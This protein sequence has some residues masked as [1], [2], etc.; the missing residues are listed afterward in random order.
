VIDSQRLHLAAPRILLFAIFAIRVT[1]IDRFAPLFD[2]DMTRAVVN[3]VLAGDFRNNWKFADVPKDFHIDFYNFSS[4][5]YVDAAFVKLALLLTDGPPAHPVHWHRMCS[6]VAGTF[7]VFLFYLLAR[8]WFDEI[9]ALVFLALAAVAPI[10]VQDAHYA[11]PEAVEILLVGAVYLL[12]NQLRGPT[13][14]YSILAVSCACVGFLGAMKFS[15]LPMLAV[16]LF[17]VPED[18][19]KARGNVVRVGATAI[20]STIAGMFAGV[21]H[22]FFHPAGY[23]HGVRVLQAQYAGDPRDPAYEYAFGVEL[24]YFWWTLGPVLVLLAVLAAIAQFRTIP[25]AI[26]RSLCLPIGFYF[27][28]FGLQ[29]IFFERN[30]S[31]VVPLILMLS[32]AGLTF[33]VRWVR[34]R[35]KPRWISSA[36]AVV[37]FI[38]AV[39]PPALVSYRLV[40]VALRI[41]SEERAKKCEANLVKKFGLPIEKTGW[42]LSEEELHSFIDIAQENS[43]GTLVRVVD[44]NHVFMKRHVAELCK[45]VPT[46]EVEFFPS[47][48]QDIPASTLRDYHSVAFRYFL[49]RPAAGKPI[50]DVTEI[51]GWKFRR[52]GGISRELKTGPVEMGSWVDNGYY[53]DVGPPK[54]GGRCFGSWTREKGD[55]NTGVLHLGPTEL[56]AE[57]R[58]LIPIVTGPDPAPI[59]IVVKDHQSGAELARMNPPSLEKW[60]LWQVD[61]PKGRK[62]AVDIVASD[63]GSGMGQWMAIGVPRQHNDFMQLGDVLPIPD[64]S[65][66]IEGSWT[67]NGYFPPVGP[68]PVPG[69]VYGSWS[70][71]DANVGRLRLKPVCSPWQLSIGIPLV[72]GPANAG[73]SVKVLNSKTGK[74]IAALDPPPVRVNWWSWNIALPLEPDSSIEIV[75]QDRGAGWGQWLAIGQPHALR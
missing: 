5:F 19:W 41:Q 50:T 34:A 23:W 53:P 71:S 17:W 48:F 4:Y 40:G 3:N 62:V 13:F 2:E 30:L 64:R 29:R 55:A 63:Q 47:L 7:A 26:W 14:R 69:M 73:L 39:A 28:V 60:M 36:M 27:A 43:R 61:L 56:I 46:Q 59:S 11:R 54:H 35:A 16:V 72:T 21:P 70:G 1:S 18:L 51:G 22:A 52:F 66:T 24:S 74:V 9:T 32:A 57:P 45:R 8:K 6:G 58:I 33:T 49:L 37:L 10:L 67:Q 12:S 75:A 20:G 31:H 65:V 15:L 38:C 42:L 68:P 25:K 44:V